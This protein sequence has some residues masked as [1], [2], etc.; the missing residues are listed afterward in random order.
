MRTRN[1]IRSELDQAIARRA[2]L[3]NRLAGGSD[4]ET[5][6][7]LAGLS[8]DIDELWNEFRT[9]GVRDRFGSPELILTRARTEERL[10]RESRRVKE[11]A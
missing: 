4:A 7:E 5:S 11:A 1:E 10:E 3:W 6:A 2:E 9:V 8:K